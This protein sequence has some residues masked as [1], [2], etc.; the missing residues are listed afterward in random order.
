MVMGLVM[1]SVVEDPV[2]QSASDDQ[3]TVLNVIHPFG[4]CDP[5]VVLVRAPCY[6]LGAQE[7]AGRTGPCPSGPGTVCKA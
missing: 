7:W 2:G 6:L 1:V 5:D 3:L 4:R